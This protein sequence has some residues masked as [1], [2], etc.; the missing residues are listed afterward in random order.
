[1]ALTAVHHPAGDWKKVSLGSMGGFSAYGGGSGDSHLI[2]LWNSTATGV[3]EGGS[4]GSGIFSAVGSPASEYRLRGG[5]HGGPSSCSATGADLRDYYSRFDRAYSFLSQYLNPGTTCSY[6]LSPTSQSVGA[7]ASSGSFGVTA[8]SGCT[9][10]AT[11]NASW[12]TTSSSGSGSG[13]VNYSVAANT[14]AARSGTISVGGQTFTISQSAGSGGTPSS[15]ISNGGFESGTSGWVQQATSGQPIITTSPSIAHTGSVVAWLGGYVSGTDIVYQDVTI[16]AGASQVTLAYWYLISTQEPAG[17]TAYDIM[18]VSIQNP[19][20]GATLATLASYSNVNARSG[21]FQSQSFDLSAYAGQTVR[22]RF[23]AVNDFSNYSSFFIDDITLTAVTSGGT[24]GNNYTALW[25]NPSENGW[26]INF[27]HQG[28]IL[29]GTLYTYDSSGQP[30]WLVMSD[31]AAAVGREHATP[32]RST[33]RP[34]RR[35]TRC[36]SRRSGRATSRPWGPCR[37]RSR[38]P[39]RARSPIRSTASP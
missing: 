1:M 17:S 28:N 3:T 25:W 19:S 6:T 12:I 5:L 11:S 31:G 33:A 8:A 22:L 16:P 24:T 10:S 34:A 13:T 35:S 2:A 38:A 20:T 37:S 21:W 36:R 32:A 39:A 4:S 29:F 14:G 23:A 30:L 27:N 9:W 26:G 18:T 15:L 7:A